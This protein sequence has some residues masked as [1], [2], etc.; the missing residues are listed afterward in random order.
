[1]LG[2]QQT[3]DPN[4]VSA[5]A[6][7]IPPIP[8]SVPKYTRQKTENYHASFATENEGV[9]N[10]LINLCEARMYNAVRNHVQFSP[11]RLLY[12]VL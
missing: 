11:R 3:F 8:M 5:S 1:M 9:C 6:A 7:S 2:R 4:A 10:M 12:L